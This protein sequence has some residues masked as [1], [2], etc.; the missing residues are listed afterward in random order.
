VSAKGK[1]LDRSHREIDVK[2]R[3]MMH[4]SLWTRMERIRRVERSPSEVPRLGFK[5]LG[6]EECHWREEY[7]RIQSGGGE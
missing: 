2:N 4:Q 6:A 3:S 7:E 5:G 1:F